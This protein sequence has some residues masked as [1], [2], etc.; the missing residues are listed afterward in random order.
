MSEHNEDQDFQDLLNDA[1]TEANA[2]VASLIPAGSRKFRIESC[3]IKKYERKKEPGIWDPYLVLGMDFAVDDEVANNLDFKGMD[4]IIRTNMI[5][6][7]LNEAG[8]IAT[9]PNKNVTLG[10]IRQAA[11]MNI[12]GV[13]FLPTN[14]VGCVIE[15][16]VK[17]S[18]RSDDPS[19][20]QEK[21][22]NFRASE[23]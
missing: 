18:P 3:K 10:Q 17:H 9:G 8:K 2:T 20:L 22:Q 16:I 6:L 15:T 4:K 23:G 1:T 13:A 12:A 5:R 14:L 19:Q 11:G 21:F 7:D